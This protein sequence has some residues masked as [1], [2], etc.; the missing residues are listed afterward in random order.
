MRNHYGNRISISRA[1]YQRFFFHPVFLCQACVES[2][3]CK[4][5]ILR[6]L[7]LFV[8]ILSTLILPTLMGALNDNKIIQIL[9]SDH[10]IRANMYKCCKVKS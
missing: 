8:K 10:Y 6:Y 3:V 9:T 7:L 2:V 4:P 5:S 1:N